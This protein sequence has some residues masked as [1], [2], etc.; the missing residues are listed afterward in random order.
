[1]NDPWTDGGRS[2]EQSEAGRS[3]ATA[4]SVGGRAR[5][6]VIR[7]RVQSRFTSLS[8]RGR[9]VVMATT[10][11]V[12][13]GLATVAATA[14]VNSHDPNPTTVAASA[15]DEQARA[16]AAQRGDRS[17]RTAPNAAASTSAAPKAAAKAAPQATKAAPKAATTT[18]APAP[19]P[20]PKPAW[21]TPM[22]GAETTSCFGQRWG[23]LHAGVDLAMP[24][25]TP[26]HTAG[27]GTVVSTGWAYSG[28]GISVVVNHGN[29]YQTHYAHMSKAAV[30]VGQKVAAGQTIGYEG[31]TGDS[32]G[33]HLH[34]EVHNGLWNQVDPAPWMRARGVNLGC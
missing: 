12:G 32:T 20:K 18:K 10:A 31:S 11:L 2:S 28:Y 33:P 3:P 26:I 24:N 16:E 21:V 6:D 1:M 17:Q 30:S 7:H 13:V 23:V 5:I 34:F 22:P 29:G 8:G 15:A 25:G 4:N 14:A 19:K 27:A 9:L